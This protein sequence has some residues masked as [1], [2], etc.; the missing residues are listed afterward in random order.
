[1]PA[2]TMGRLEWALFLALSFFWGASFY[3]YKLL[4]SLGPFT[5]VLGRMGIAAV[6]MNL[7]LLARGESLPRAAQWG[8]YFFMALVANVIPFTLFAYGEHTISSGLA[9]IIN[10][11]TPIFTVIVAHF[12]THN[13]KFSWN[14]G[15]GVLCG[16]AGVTLLVGPSAFGG[17]NNLI[18]ELACVGSTISYGFGGVYGKRF[19]G[20]SLFAVV[21][22]QLTAATILVAPLALLVEHPWTL[23]APD[24]DVWGALVG[25][26]LIST[27]FAYLIFFHILAK[28]GATY[29]SLVTFLIPVSGLFL[30]TVLLNETV[31][32]T[33]IAGMLVIALGLA[34]ID[35]R[36][37]QWL[38]RPAAV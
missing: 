25:I 29:I 7:I 4:V 35:G 26:A 3:F 34:A 27:V 16:L 5:I 21:T 17:S 22:A 30:G 20:R 32:A 12:W 19:S 24:L 6:I 11:M 38:R 8:P 18:G 14:K 31:A 2:G 37:F 1:M 13:E 9:S 28:A 36:A 23:P 33:D 15:V 10:A